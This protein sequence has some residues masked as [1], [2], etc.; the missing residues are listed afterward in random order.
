M[1]NILIE[2]GI[3]MKLVRLIKTC[4]NETYSRVLV[5]RHLSDMFPIKHSWKQGDALSPFP[6]NFPLQYAI[7]RVQVYH[8][9]LKLNG[10]HR[11]LV[12]AENVNILGGSVHTRVIS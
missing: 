11:I 9:G 6:F 5:G 10:T 3:P 2:S 4:L 12:Y 1:Y 7:W 8:D